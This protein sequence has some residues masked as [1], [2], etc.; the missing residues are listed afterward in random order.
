MRVFVVG[1]MAAGKSTVS[2][3]LARRLQ[4][5]FVDLDRRVER[6]AGGRLPEVF[7]RYG[8]EG[9]RRRETLALREACAAPRL[10]VATGGGAFARPENRDLIKKYGTSVFLDPPFDVLWNRLMNS[11]TERPL[12]KGEHETRALWTARRGSYL[13]ADLV[14]AVSGEGE[15]AAVA[16]LIVEALMEN[17][18]V[19]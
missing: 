2:R 7:E 19:T 16:D 11:P 6:M 1:F 10:V 4:W 9:F 13:E 15:P 18:C 8:E 14:I 12:L 3:H 17:P 5:D